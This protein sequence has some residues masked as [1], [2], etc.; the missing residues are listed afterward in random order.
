MHPAFQGFYDASVR[1]SSMLPYNAG[2][3]TLNPTNFSVLGIKFPVSMRTPTSTPTA[4]PE[5]FARHLS[6]ATLY[7]LSLLLSNMC[8]FTLDIYS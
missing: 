3:L 1:L 4:S 2:V 8:F 5:L 7:L 6:S